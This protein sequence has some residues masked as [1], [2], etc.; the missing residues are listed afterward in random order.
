MK[1]MNRVIHNTRCAPILESNGNLQHLTAK[2]PEYYSCFSHEVRYYLSL[3]ALIEPNLLSSKPF[4][5]FS[6]KVQ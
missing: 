2:K 5:P 3:G 4:L 6:L 1:N